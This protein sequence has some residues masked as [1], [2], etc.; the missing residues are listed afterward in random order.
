MPS[1]G[2]AGLPLRARQAGATAKEVAMNS[3]SPAW[4]RDFD[5][6]MIRYFLI[7]H[8]DAGMDEAVLLRYADLPP[9][10]AALQFGED[11]ELQRVDADWVAPSS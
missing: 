10:A 2:S 9:Q 1:H 5:A 4:L 7:D 8:L 3:I 6:A 11:Y